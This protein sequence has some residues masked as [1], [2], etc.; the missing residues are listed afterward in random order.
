[1]QGAEGVY[2]RHED[3][4][5]FRVRVLVDV[6]DLLVFG[7][8][9]VVL[10]VPLLMVF[11]SGRSTARAIFLAWG[12]IAFLYFVVLKRSNFRTLGYRAG[13]VRIVG[14]DGRRPSY[15]SL[16]VRFMFGMLGPLN[17]PIDLIWLTNDIHRQALRDKFANTCLVSATAQSMGAGRIVF[18]QYDIL[19]YNFLFREV[20][21]GLEPDHPE[22]RR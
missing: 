22:I 4:A 11:P 1:M 18:R 10:I 5:P 12:V 21:V 6:V 2:F 19:F 14:L 15:W 17:W 9:C 13:R 3:Y 7:A 20:Q 8:L 16:I